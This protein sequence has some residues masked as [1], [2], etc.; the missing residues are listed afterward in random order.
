M[1]RRKTWCAV[2]LRQSSLCDG[3]MVRK[4]KPISFDCPPWMHHA[5][6][7][8]P[9]AEICVEWRPEFLRSAKGVAMM[10]LPIARLLPSLGSRW[11]GRCRCETRRGCLSD[12]GFEQYVVVARDC[13]CNGMP[14]PCVSMLQHWYTLL[15][16]VDHWVTGMKRKRELCH[17]GALF[18]CARY[19]TDV[20]C[21]MHWLR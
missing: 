10:G 17:G 13:N 11:L 14:A 1:S 6:H 15:S 19:A 16:W 4:Q 12:V 20:R 18:D 3:M 9:S 8:M 21:N 5:S 2:C 7:S